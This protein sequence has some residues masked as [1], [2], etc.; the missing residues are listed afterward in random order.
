MVARLVRRRRRGW[1][2]AA[3]LWLVP[4]LSP[5][6]S[7]RSRRAVSWT[8]TAYSSV[9]RHPPAL[10]SLTWPAS[11]RRAS[12]RLPELWP[13]V[14]LA[15]SV[16]PWPAMRVELSLVAVVRLTAALMS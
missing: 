1:A 3:L 13:R 7:A 4:S 10:R 2:V 11:V 15:L 9:Q 8:A 12:V 5:D 16:G 14:R 6:P